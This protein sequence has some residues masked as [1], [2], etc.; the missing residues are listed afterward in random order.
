MDFDQLL[1]QMANNAE[2]IR[3]FTEGIS[4]DRARWRPDPDSWSLLE[5]INHLY[6]EERED[7]RLRLDHILYQPDR[8]WHAIDPQ[9][10]VTER[11][12]NE[13]DLAESIRNFLNERQQSLAWLQRLPEMDWEKS[14][15][16]PFGRITAGDMFAAWVAHDLL[17]LRQLV[18]LH[19]AYTVQ[20]VQPY[21]VR[22]AGEW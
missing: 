6:D 19:W 10:W 11:S 5:V 3:S 20:S 17:H 1:A 14:A 4:N 7:F 15:E 18:E 9:G 13:R 21:S 2:T 12:Y 22:Y 8:P 16:A